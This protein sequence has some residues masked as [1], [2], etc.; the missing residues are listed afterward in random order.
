[1]DSSRADRIQR[2]LEE[3]FSPEHL[4]VLNESDSH[5]VPKGSETHFKVVLVSNRF[6]GKSRV[7][8]H[9]M[10]YGALEAEFKAKLHALSLVTRTPEE[11]AASN[12]VPASPECAGA[13]KS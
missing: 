10:V 13:R 3:A 7:E 2:S 6:D 8:R 4:S 9:T 5:S 1:M 12:A 11:W